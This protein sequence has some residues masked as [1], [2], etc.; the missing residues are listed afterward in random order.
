MSKSLTNMSDLIYKTKRKALR[1]KQGFYLPDREN[2]CKIRTGGEMEQL[3]VEIMHKAEK[4][5]TYISHPLRLRILEYLDVY[6]ASSVSEITK[7]LQEEQVIISQNLRKLREANL[8]K[9]E[10]HGL[11]I[12][13]D[14]QKEYPASI[15]VCLR[16]LF[17]YMAN[18]FYF[19]QDGYKALL[20]KDYTT[21]AAN[22]IKLFANFEK[23]RI[24]E[25]L[26]ANGEKNVS[27]IA[28]GVGLEQLKVSQHLKKLKEDEFVSCERQ[29]R[30]IFYKIL[31]GVHY[32]ALL[33][34]HHRYDSLQDKSQ[35]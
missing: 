23:M 15:F 1:K 5:I 19:L 8:V 11:F 20:P 34:I 4:G 12:F 21:M 30:F 35:F 29:G 26:L 32:T 24:L 16:K 3:P 33:C 2:N 31:K 17:G 25:F 28:A 18:Q 10:R 9:T 14:V 13:Y 6:G 7:A 22:R 27:D